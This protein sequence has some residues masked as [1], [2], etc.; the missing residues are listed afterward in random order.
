MGR[1][2]PSPIFPETIDSEELKSDTSDDE[3]ASQGAHIQNGALPMHGTLTNQ[4]TH[5]QA[6]TNNSPGLLMGD[7][8]HAHLDSHVNTETHSAFSVVAKQVKGGRDDKLHDDSTSDMSHSGSGS[9]GYKKRWSRGKS[10]TV[11]RDLAPSLDSSMSSW[12]L[13]ALQQGRNKYRQA[14]GLPP[15]EEVNSQDT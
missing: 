15:E 5:I 13:T 3:T 12:A 9:R 11:T 2:A 6:P 4:G 7:A 8:A 1:R 10:S 14:M